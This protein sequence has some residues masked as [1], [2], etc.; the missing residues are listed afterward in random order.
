MIQ[1]VTCPICKKP[2]AP[3]AHGSACFPF[4]SKRC[5]QVDLVRWMDGKYAVVEELDPD[6]IML[7]QFEGELP[8]D[9]DLED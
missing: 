2:L 8:T 6:Q 4:C 5:K 7:Q 9:L 3:E 1:P